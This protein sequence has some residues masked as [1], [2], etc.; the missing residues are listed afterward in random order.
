MSTGAF[1]QNRPMASR[2]QLARRV[3]VALGDEPA[4][5]VLTGGR[6]ANV[7]TG[8]VHEAAV[9]I[10]DGVI[11][12]VGDYRDARTIVDVDGLI[13][14]PALIDSHIHVESSL[15]SPAEFAHTIAAA[16][17]GTVVADPHEIA[18]VCGP[19]GVEWMRAELAG[20]PADVRLQA[21]PCVPASPLATTGGRLAPDDV[22]HLLAH[23]NALGLAEVMDFPGAIG[24]DEHLLDKIVAAAGRPIDGHCPSL[25][26][27]R[28]QAYVALGIS[29]DHECTTEQEAR[30][31]LAAGL[32]VMARSGSTAEDLDAL[33][34]LIL[35]QHGRRILL[36]NDDVTVVDLLERGHLTEHLRRVVGAGLDPVAALRTVTLNAAEHFNLADRG[37]IAP[38]RRAD[39]VAFEDLTAFAVAAVWHVG[40][41][42]ADWAPAGT[43]QPIGLPLNLPAHVDL[44]AEPRGPAIGF[45]PESLLTRRHD[46]PDEQDA[47]LL[48]VDRYNGARHAAARVRGFGITRGALA[49]TV[50]HDH[51]NLM[52]IGT[53]RE[54]M[55][56]AIELM[57][58]TRGGMQVVADGVSRAHLPLDLGGLMS[59]LPARDVARRYEHARR[60]A[61]ALG[62]V[63]RDP[64][65]ALSFLGLEVIPELKLTDH[66]LVD[67]LAGRILD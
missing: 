11:A 41:A 22:A 39:I 57:R 36:V 7:F 44:H 48:A 40:I 13:L 46:D 51:H 53:D 52:V 55:A 27:R 9:A 38:G 32:S 25:T 6:V 42:L 1:R 16:G 15:L 18:N 5:L 64:L 59:T 23:P 8:D 43:P 4:D 66:G 17:T 37:A 33:M 54:D 56:H 60:E 29:S 34:P 31:K 35:A 19:S 30:E 26:G 21:S 3:A 12:G 49:T 47:L 58:G 65:M 14:A 62:C 2:E 50:A 10:V 24:G 61:R 45:I 67:V 28:L 63:A 20:S